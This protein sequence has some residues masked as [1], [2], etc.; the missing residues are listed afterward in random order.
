MN[1]K[2]LI[3]LF[4]RELCDEHD[5]Y[6]WETTE[7]VHYLNQAI[8]EACE[9]ALLIED[10]HTP[11][12]CWFTARQ[13]MDTYSLHPCVLKIKRLTVG[14]RPLTET[15]VQEMDEQSPGWERRT[16]M[17][18][19]FI[20]EGAQGARPPKVQLVPLPSNDMDVHMTVYRGALRP[21]RESCEGEVPDFPLSRIDDLKHW[22]YRCALLKPDADSGDQ[23]R[24]A[25]HEQLFTQ[26][27]GEK[28]DANTAR[29][30]RDR[31]PPIV[32]CAW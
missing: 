21:L 30:R 10:R 15:S 24:A 22:V 7:L 13:G 32:Q 1:L 4:R 17:P 20:F 23:G 14:G 27:F 5:P 29:K 25:Q 9:R 28:V 19:H 18:T 2:N 6:L 3:A 31:R 26:A 8:Q 11:E 16:G 12:V